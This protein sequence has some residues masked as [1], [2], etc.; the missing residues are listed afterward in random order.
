MQNPFKPT[1]GRIPPVLV[2]REDIISDFDYAMMDGVG[3]PGRLMFITG[4]RGVGKTVMLDTL[5][6]RAR[7]QG[8]EVIDE[9]ADCG[10][11]QRLVD[12]LAG[13]EDAHIS[14]YNMPELGV[15]GG[16][17][18]VELN[19]GRVELDRREERPLTL[20]RAVGARLDEMDE[21][22]QG[23]LITLDEVQSGSMDEIRALSIAMQHLI[24]EGRNVAL[25]FAGLPSAVN[26]VLSDKAIRFLQ[27]AERYHLGSVPVEKVLEAFEESFGGE[28]KAGME[29][30]IRLTKATHGYPFMIQL[31]GYWAWRLS[32]INGHGE[33]VTEED[34]EQGIERAKVKL[35]DM[36]HMPAL[37]KL[38]TQAINYLLAM[39]VDDDVSNTGEVARR[40]NRSPQFGNVY[41]TMLIENDL[42]EP[43][44]YGKVAFKMPYL[45][46][47][48]REHGAYLQMRENISEM[49]GE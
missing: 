28:K 9:T 27:R 46:D 43:V 36:V 10:F 47:Y 2:G 13:K 29:T 12:T 20:R 49:A 42:I 7:Q 15:D 30:L 8:W 26:E 16:F 45:R 21:S 34:A 48:L 31:V 38:P 1:A 40:M 37:R 11:I 44:A 22:S 23:I 3:S 4:A 33:W 19:L 14:A 32:E 39:S 24:R 41:R 6:T 18:K 17:G 35:G 25:I 5:G